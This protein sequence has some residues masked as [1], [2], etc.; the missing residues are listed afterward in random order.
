MEE[1]EEIKYYVYK[2]TN[3][4]NEKIY[5]G[6]HKSKD[7][8]NDPYLGSGYILVKSIKHHGK[9]NF[10]REILFDFTTVE[11]AF[12]KEKEIVNEDFVA[13]RDTYNTALGGHGGKIT[14]V[15]PFLGKTH[16][17][18][19]IAKIL[20]S[21]AWYKP[22]QET[23]DK[24]SKTLLEQYENMTYEEICDLLKVKFGKD[25]YFYGKHHTQETIDKILE[26]RAWYKPTQE[27]KD[28][29]SLQRKG[30]PKSEEFKQLMSELMTG[31]ECPWNQITNRDPEK[32]RKTAEKH[33]GMKRSEEACK[34]IS[35]SLKGKFKAEESN[36][37][38]GYWNTPFGKFPSL[39]LAADA[40]NNGFI[41][42]RDRCLKNERIITKCSVS[43]DK[44][45][46][47]SD[48]GKTWKELGWFFESVENKRVGK[49]LKDFEEN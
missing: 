11:E 10:K 18:E 28:L 13:R 35:E 47:E 49:N 42:V 15:N 32:I 29:W 14:E 36:S 46:S 12:A 22:T 48:I 34:N 25:N 20:E 38:K 6:V 43:R 37:F 40:S 16:S 23:K 33:T 2:T 27:T 5:V 45:I 21:R 39:E 7:I 30:V 41:C 1:Q 24:I 8:E 3:V 31:R 4:I 19:T 17:P 44:N 9:D 26:S